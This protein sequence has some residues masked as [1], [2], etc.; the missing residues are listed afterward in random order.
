MATFA[1][2]SHA[3]RV[4]EH[5]EDTIG[6]LPELGLY[7]V[8]DGMGGH[9]S[10][11]VASRIAVDTLLEAAVRMSLADALVA[12]H[13][14]VAR[15]AALDVSRRGMGSTAVALRIENGIA[16]LAWVGDSRGYLFRNGVM[17]RLTRDHSLVGL[18]LERAEVTEADAARHPQRHIVTQ[19]LGHGEPTPSVAEARLKAGDRLLLCSD[20]LNDELSD[21]EIA[22]VLRDVPDIEGAAQQ[23]IDLAL[24]RGGRDNI[25]V[26]L[27]A[28]GGDD[29]AGGSGAPSAL[30]DD[31]WRAVVA[32]AGGAALLAVLWWVLR[33]NGLF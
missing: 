33:M 27:V 3:G 21:E 18:M 17:T 9:A 16:R 22:S 24:A 23:L 5:N 7:L 12:A 8:A 13:R 30:K 25:S 2:R 4:Y 19:T 28:F 26:V 10:G 14:A 11:E 6:V 20:G 32:G 31:R 29:A 15:A 1:M